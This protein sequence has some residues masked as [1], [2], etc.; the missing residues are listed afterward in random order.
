MAV[1]IQ[2]IIFPVILVLLISAPVFAQRELVKDI[3]GDNI[4]DSVYIDSATSAIVCKLSGKNFKKVTSKAIETLNDIS[5][6]TEAKNG[7]EFYNDWMRAGYKNQFRYDPASKKI[8][9]IGMSRYEFGNASNDGSGESS[10][11]LLTNSY[12]GNWNFY[13]ERREKLVS[14]PTIKTNMIFPAIYLEGFGEDTYFE[15]ADRCAT[16][17]QQRKEQLSTP[18]KRT[19]VNKR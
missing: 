2:K 18:K 8:R 6:I 3:D 10:V 17:Y 19:P 11:N 4:K 9:L 14:I 7:F 16:L 12:I 5:G 1:S 15:F 13:S